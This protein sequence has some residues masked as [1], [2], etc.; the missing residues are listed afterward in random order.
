[1]SIYGDEAQYTNR[2]FPSEAP[3]QVVRF[4]LV[5]YN[6][7]SALAWSYILITLLLH[8]TGI[9]SSAQP[10]PARAA[11]THVTSASAKLSSFFS[12]ASSRL[13][14]LKSSSSR[15]LSQAP[16]GIKAIL[17]RMATSYAA[18]GP[19]TTLV[20]SMA[21]LEVA[22]AALGWVRSPIQTTAMQVASRLFLVWGVSEQYDSVSIYI[23]FF[24]A[25]FIEESSRHAPR[26]CTQRWS[27]RGPSPK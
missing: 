22:H 17:S 23:S 20:Q 16:S 24:T 26:L 10:A 6:V 4:Y 5:A 1:M 21:I 25:C 18:V 19:E 3:S 8:L 14:Y 9:H 27:S 7:L 13:P 15:K 12:T 2:D 11:T